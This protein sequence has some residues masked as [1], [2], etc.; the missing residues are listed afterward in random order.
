MFCQASIAPSLSF[1]SE[2]ESIVVKMDAGEV[3]AMQL[4]A[5]LQRFVVAPKW[6]YSWSDQ[7]YDL[8][9]ISKND[10]QQWLINVFVS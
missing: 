4:P 1:V 2:P 3:D 6:Q 8:R 7:Q 9:M 10:A 5:V